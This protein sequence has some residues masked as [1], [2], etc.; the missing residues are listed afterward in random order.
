MRTN[1]LLWI[2]QWLLAALFLFA[3]GAKLVL[4]VEAM[5]QGSLALP[6]PFFRF[7]GVSE[8]CGGLGLVL[9]WALWIHP[10]LTPLAAGGLVIIMIGATVVTM[11]TGQVAGAL[12][13]FIVGT[14]ALFVAYQRS[15]CT[16]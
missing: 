1:A 16:V 9:P 8:V 7:I 15:R 13:P 11:L 6:G 5:Q 12:L 14:L 4:P 10:E 2:L 3:G